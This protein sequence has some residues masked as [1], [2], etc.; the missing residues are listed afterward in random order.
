M[1]PIPNGGDWSRGRNGSCLEGRVQA[2]GSPR[3]GKVPPP[4]EKAMQ[5]LRC[6]G[7][8]RFVMEASGGELSGDGGEGAM[9][10]VFIDEGGSFVKWLHGRGHEMKRLEVPM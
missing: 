5:Y 4:R 8:A 2:V 10:V 7:G 1:C 6:G 9:R 3:S